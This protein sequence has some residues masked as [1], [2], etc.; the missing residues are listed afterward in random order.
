[1][2]ET[3][4]ITSYLRELTIAKKVDYR[5]K[6]AQKKT[7]KKSGI[8]ENG[9]LVQPPVS[10]KTSQK[11]TAKKLGIIEKRDSVQPPALRK[12]SQKKITEKKAALPAA[13]IP[14]CSEPEKISKKSRE[15][16][17]CSA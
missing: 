7:A 3:R 1:M 11:K 17:I 14:L 15:G 10:R 5:G 9:D 13:P 4:N 12:T 2:A 6:T 16:I 8:I